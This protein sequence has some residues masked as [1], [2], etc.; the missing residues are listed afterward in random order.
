MHAEYLAVSGY[1]HVSLIVKAQTDDSDT[2]DDHLGLGVWCDFDYAPMPAAAGGDVDIPVT[3]KR[4][5]LRPAKPRKE[6]RDFAVGADPHHRIETRKGRSRDIKITVGPEAEVIGGHAC[7]KRRERSS[8]ADF[9]HEKYRAASIAYKHSPFRVECDAGC[10]AQV[11]REL[12]GFL[13]RSYAIDGA[14]VTAGYEH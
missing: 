8:F 3:I 12:L 1:N 4:Q 2:R 13:E 10:N 11:P 6:S 14:V 5:T 9:I 7:F